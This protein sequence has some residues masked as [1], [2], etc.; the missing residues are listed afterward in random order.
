MD[1]PSHMSRCS[2]PPTSS[3]GIPSTA[4]L[5]SLC[6]SALLPDRCAARYVGLLKALRCLPWSCPLYNNTVYSVWSC[7][8]KPWPVRL[9]HCQLH[10]Y[11]SRFFLQVIVECAWCCVAGE[12]VLLL[13]L[14]QFHSVAMALKM[15]L[16]CRQF[17]MMLIHINPRQRHASKYDAHRCYRLHNELLCCKSIHSALLHHL[18][19]QSF[20]VK[21]S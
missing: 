21:L 11:S 13:R 7:M 6:G 14:L 17:T 10:T 1:S 19:C 3:F 15:L 5:L 4:T 9:V 8:L 12:F 20:L 2:L 16:L 18:V